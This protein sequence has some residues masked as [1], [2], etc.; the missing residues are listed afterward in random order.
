VTRLRNGNFGL[1]IA[2]AMKL[3]GSEAGKLESRQKKEKMRGLAAYAPADS[4]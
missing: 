1:R 2:E 3:G 4:S